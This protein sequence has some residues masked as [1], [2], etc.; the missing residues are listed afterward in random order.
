[1]KLVIAYHCYLYGEVYDT[2]IGSQFSRLVSSKLFKACDKIYIG[3]V[4]HSPVPGSD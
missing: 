3:I 4:E 2:L 1:M